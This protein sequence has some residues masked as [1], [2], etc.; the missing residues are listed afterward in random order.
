MFDVGKNV[1]F[2][3]TPHLSNITKETNSKN[4]N[5]ANREGKSM[6]VP[7]WFIKAEQRYNHQNIRAKN[8][9]FRPSDIIL[10]KPR[11]TL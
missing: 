11:L 4:L 6:P 10:H 7:V 2:V 1:A 5:Q 3:R 8:Q 9:I